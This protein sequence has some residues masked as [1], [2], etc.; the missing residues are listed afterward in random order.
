MAARAKPQS[1]HVPCSQRSREKVRSKRRHGV[2]ISSPPGSK[3]RGWTA[4]V[5]RAAILE[6][7]LSTLRTACPTGI[8]QW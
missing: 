7:N 6:E 2:W 5:I 4:V 8:G 1:D 3:S